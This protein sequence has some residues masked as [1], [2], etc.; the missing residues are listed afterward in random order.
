MNKKIDLKNYAIIRSSIM[1][2]FKEILS[3]EIGKISSFDSPK[4]GRNEFD[5][6][7]DE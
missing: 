6:F 1:W 4:V 7:C 3:T 5:S 2:N